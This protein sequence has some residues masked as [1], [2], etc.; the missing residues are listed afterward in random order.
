MQEGAHLAWITCVAAAWWIKLWLLLVPQPR[1][2]AHRVMQDCPCHWPIKLRTWDCRER[3]LSLDNN[4]PEQSEMG[5]WYTSCW[6]MAMQSDLCS[7]GH[8]GIESKAISWWSLAGTLT[9]SRLAPLD[10]TYYIC[11]RISY[12]CTMTTLFLECFRKIAKLPVQD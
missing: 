5:R 1:R 10:G 8:K 7:P 2:A 3:P 11:E 6:R 12:S 4:Y 9:F